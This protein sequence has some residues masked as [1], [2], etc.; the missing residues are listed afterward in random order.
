M[1][2]KIPVKV[3]GYNSDG[4]TWEEATT[5][6]D[7]SPGGVRFLV[8]RPLVRGQVLHLT[9]PLP[10]SLRQYD[11][12]QPAYLVYGIVRDVEDEGAQCRAGVM[13][14]GKDPP[15]GFEERPGALYLMPSDVEAPAAPRRPAVSEPEPEPE[16]DPSD[17][18]RSRRFDIFVNFAVEQVDEWG[19]TLSDELSVAENVSRRG[20]RLKTSL[21]LAKGHIVVLREVGG[22]FE[23]RAEVVGVHVGKD[24]VRRLNLK[25]LDGRSPDHLIPKR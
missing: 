21:R 12:M 15:R 18:R 3:R 17:R 1:A 5:T 8:R 13:F 20:C 16:T 23:T 25:F 24:G 10:K 7:A 14:F 22:S 11:F 2:L 6:E 4:T 19:V 9:L